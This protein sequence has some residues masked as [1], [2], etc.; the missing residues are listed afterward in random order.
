[1]CSGYVSH[2]LLG[3]GAGSAG[4]GGVG[5][6]PGA[7]LGGAGGVPGAGGLYPGGGEK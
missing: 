7:G 2:F 6:V 3:P 5:G 1:M 4:L